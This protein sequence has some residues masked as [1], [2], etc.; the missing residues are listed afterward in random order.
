MPLWIRYLKNK[1]YHQIIRDNGP[2]TH[3]EK[4]HTPTT[5]GLMIILCISLSVLLFAPLNAYLILLLIALW[6][7]GLIGLVDDTLK[8]KK[9]HSTG[10]YA[11]S[12]YIL[13][14]LLSLLLLVG[15][16]YLLPHS[17][18]FQFIPFLHQALPIGFI[19][20]LIFGYFAL[21]G[22][23]NAVNLTDGLD[24]L[25][26]MPI[27]MS[28]MVFFIIASAGGAA[29]IPAHWHMMQQSQF[30]TV[31][32][33]L[34]SIVGATLGFLCYNCYPA[35]IFMG[36]VGSLALGGVLALSAMMLS[37]V[38]LLLIVGGVFVLETLSVILQVGY[39]KISKGKR[40]FKMAPLHHHFELLGWSETKVTHTFW[41]LSLVFLILSLLAIGVW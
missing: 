18:H 1:H 17:H 35:K 8:I 22:T 31:A 19:G 4:P 16:Y 38:F 39:F 32:L 29:T 27:I 21:V 28:A 36:D 12:K 24:G 41:I 6:G 33:F 25:V 3:L 11:K 34:I 20:T 13:L 37:H 9:Q 40:I 10:L 2:R 15:L 14:S 7:F 30:H 5:G 23:S 26:S